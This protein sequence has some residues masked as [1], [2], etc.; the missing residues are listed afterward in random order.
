MIQRR[1][2]EKKTLKEQCS[3]E[4]ERLRRMKLGEVKEL[5][6]AETDSRGTHQE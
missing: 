3:G 5:V 6:G 1:V 4:V 2:D